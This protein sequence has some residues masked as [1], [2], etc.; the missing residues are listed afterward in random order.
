MIDHCSVLF[1]FLEGEEHSVLKSSSISQL[2]ATSDDEK[3]KKPL[4]FHF[5]VDIRNII[6]VLKS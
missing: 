5:D 1:C 3:V 6:K 4:I 2:Y